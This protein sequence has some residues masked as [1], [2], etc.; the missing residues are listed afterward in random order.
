MGLK[1]MESHK[2]MGSEPDFVAADHNSERLWDEF[3]I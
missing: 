3:G 1:V 2:V